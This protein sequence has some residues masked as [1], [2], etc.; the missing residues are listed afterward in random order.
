M[1]KC[2]LEHVPPITPDPFRE[3]QIAIQLLPQ[4]S[5][6]LSPEAK[7]Q[8]DLDCGK[9]Q[10]SS[11]ASPPRQSGFLLANAGIHQA[12]RTGVASPYP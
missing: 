8:L 10:H 4:L 3:Q 12:Y 1:Q 11:M 2:S 9:L 6:L 7:I 5:V